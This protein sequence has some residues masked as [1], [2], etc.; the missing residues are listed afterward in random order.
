MAGRGTQ[1]VKCWGDNVA[2]VRIIDSCPQ[3]QDK[4]G[5]VTPQLWCN[6]NIY[7]FDLSFHAFEKLAHPLYGVMNVEFRPV[8][9]DTRQPIQFLPGGPF[10][11]LPLF[12]FSRSPSLSG[13][14][15][16][17]CGTTA[18]DL[19]PHS[20]VSGREAGAGRGFHRKVTVNDWRDAGRTLNLFEATSVCMRE[21]GRGGQREGGL[22]GGRVLCSASCLAPQRNQTWDP[23]PRPSISYHWRQIGDRRLK[24]H[25][26]C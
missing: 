6:G 5:V 3:Y 23:S 17:S 21:R 1:D 10:Y 25:Y 13:K 15:P 7:H 20:I 16:R 11:P 24:T 12:T 26:T 9:C 14:E 22:G 2:F 4:N 18:L 19:A 8:D